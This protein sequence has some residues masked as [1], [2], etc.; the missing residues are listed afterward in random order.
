MAWTSMHFAVGMLGGG[1]LGIAAS[2]VLRRGSR[3]IPLAMTA[4]GFWAI[5]PDLPRLWREDFPSLPLAATLGD[6]ELENY[7]HSIG[8]LFFLHARL[9]AQPK[10][11]ALHGLILILFLYN[12]ALLWQLMNPPRSVLEARLLKQMQRHRRRRKPG[13]SPVLSDHIESERMK[14][15]E[16]DGV[17]GRISHA[18]LFQNKEN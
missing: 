1:A 4:G 7:L 5:T 15:N 14:D 9:D 18:R 8:D 12:A 2:A 10:E 17:I 13:H 3:W 16:P 11:Y 6:K